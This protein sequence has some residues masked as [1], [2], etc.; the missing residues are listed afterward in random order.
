MLSQI[1]KLLDGKKSYI[2]AILIG[3]LSFWMALHPTFVVPEWV[4]TSLAA[5]GLGAVRSAIGN[6]T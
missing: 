5:L 2:V 6:K 1:E 4:W 3:G